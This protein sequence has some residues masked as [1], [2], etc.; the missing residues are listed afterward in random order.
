MN[1]CPKCGKP[2]DEKYHWEHDPRTDEIR[3]KIAKIPGQNTNALYD[4]QKA[5]RDIVNDIE[6]IL[7]K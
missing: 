1:K 6:K 3:K 5:V 7:G 2:V 4:T